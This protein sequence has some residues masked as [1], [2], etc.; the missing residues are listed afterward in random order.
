MKFPHL[1]IIVLF[2]CSSISYAIPTPPNT[3]TKPNNPPLSVNPSASS[4][5]VTPSEEADPD[6]G[7]AFENDSLITIPAD[8]LYNFTW[9]SR[10]LNPYR[11][12]ID[13]LP[14]SVEID[15][16]DFVFPVPN[17][18]INSN[19]GIRRGRFHY[20]TD[21]ALTIGDTVRATFSGIVRIVD[22]ERRGYG[23]YVVIRH[24]NS[25]ESVSAHLSK[26]FVTTNQIVEAGDPIGL[27]GNSGRST[28]PHLHYELRF[29]GNAFN[30]TKLIDYP[31]KTTFDDIY[32]L[33]KKHTFNHNA[34]LKQLA[35]VRY[36]IVKSGDTL[37]RI[38]N[39]YR[40][41]V[42]NLCRLNKIKA[43]SILRIGQR[44][45]YR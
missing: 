18:R 42:G 22:Y 37:S 23:H 44:I 1:F 30:T 17:N 7:F 28:G 6:E 41:T 33:T 39:R 4:G 36:H 27:G 9:T 13:S 31:N 34:E 25:L 16:C 20:G 29:L 19:F 45:R 11:I 35:A 12:S 40:T 10:H 26:T 43:T 32:L 24:N 15:C 21:I 5:Q 14:D 3:G 8:E 2:A 38:A